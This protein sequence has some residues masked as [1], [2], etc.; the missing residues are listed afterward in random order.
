MPTEHKIIWTS[1]GGGGASTLHA[2]SAATPQTVADAI[3]AFLVQLKAGLSN[4]VTMGQSTEVRILDDATGQLTGV[5]NVTAAAP[6]AGNVAGQPVADA[7]QILMRWNTG[8]IVNGRRLVGRTFVPGLPVASLQ[9]GNLAGASALDF[10]SKGNALVSSLTGTNRLVVWHRPKNGAGGTVWPINTC[11]V[12]GEMA[13]LR[14][15][16]G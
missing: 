11:T 8:F 14:R 9:G 2:L 15:R 7:S 3:D 10:A 16:R 5:A 4:Q 13:V 12:W 6:V 1:P